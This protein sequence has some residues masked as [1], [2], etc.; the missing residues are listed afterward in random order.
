MSQLDKSDST[1]G[2]RF[3]TLW[4]AANTL[5]MTVIYSSMAFAFLT[6]QNAEYFIA[7]T[8]A[9]L[10]AIIGFIA[11][12]PLIGTLQWLVLKRHCDLSRKWVSAS[13]RGWIAGLIVAFAVSA[14][15]HIGLA[16]WAAL[17]ATLGYMQTRIL[18]QL[19]DKTHYW[20]VANA[21]A[22]ALA[23][24]AIGVMSMLSRQIYGVD[25]SPGL[26]L[27]TFILVGMVGGIVA[28]GTTGTAMVWL[29]RSSATKVKYAG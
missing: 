14:A 4:L 21:V 1:V 7:I 29:L 27:P 6:L 8:S 13:T 2:V 9:I 19:V 25:L 10:I 5:G 17:G 16:A 24:V 23:E 12:G 11:I 28:G 20:V 22:L 26:F 15:T 18:G 3:W